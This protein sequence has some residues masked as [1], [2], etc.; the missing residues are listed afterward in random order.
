MTVAFDESVLLWFALT[1][2]GGC[3]IVP[4]AETS[5]ARRRRRVEVDEGLAV[6]V[7]STIRAQLIVVA[8]AGL[9]AVGCSPYEDELTGHYQEVELD[10]LQDEAVAV[11]FFRFGGDARAVLRYYDIASSAA[12]EAPFDPSH[13]THCRWSR[14]AEFDEEDHRFSL[15]IPATVRDERIVLDGVIGEDGIMEL[16]IDAEQSEELR[17]VTLEQSDHPPDSDCSTIDDFFIRAIFEDTD[18]FNGFSP[19]VYE[20]RNP[21]FS[22][23]WVSVEP[24]TRSGVPVYVALNDPEPSIRLADGVH[25]NRLD[26]ELTGNLS[27]SIPPPAERILVDSGQ[28]RYALAHFVV[29][30]DSADEEGRFSWNVDDEPIVATALEKGSPD[31]ELED[32]ITGWGKALLFVEGNVDEL[33]EELRHHFEGMEQAELDR[34]F[35]I[36]DVFFI[37]DQVVSLRLPAR[38]EAERPVHRRVP[39]QV[40]EEHLE[41]GEVPVP[42]LFHN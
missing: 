22:L 30:D 15:V 36:V 26:N 32:E 6:S 38:P 8:A 10:E 39:V 2:G 14:V 29:I 13:Q 25:F 28:T 40:T 7:L 9:L 42:R 21:V 16:T 12:R 24:V 5:F 4:G 18:N 41:A 17:E 3:V 23:L 19:D 34:H 11:D 31:P 33:D 27:L 37:N 20:M 1:T 35:Y